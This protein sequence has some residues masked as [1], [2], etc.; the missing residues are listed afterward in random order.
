MRLLSLMY[1]HQMLLSLRLTRYY[2][3]LHLSTL[4]CVCVCV[5]VCVLSCL[6]HDFVSSDIWVV[7]NLV[8]SVNELNPVIDQKGRTYSKSWFCL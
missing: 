6:L 7:Q 8:G 1:T 5:C 2:C 3:A 4:M